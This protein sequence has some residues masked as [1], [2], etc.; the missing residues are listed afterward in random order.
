ME[1]DDKSNTSKGPP[2]S[3]ILFLTLLVSVSLFR[4]NS[5]RISFVQYEFDTRK[6]WSI[7]MDC[8]QS[9]DKNILIPLEY[10]VLVTHDYEWYHIIS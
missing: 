7:D 2:H 6:I 5:I 10:W 8:P 9:T 3:T 4:D 1:I